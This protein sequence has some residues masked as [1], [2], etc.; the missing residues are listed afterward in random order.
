MNYLILGNGFDLAH[1]YKTRYQDFL[2]WVKQEV[3]LYNSLDTAARMGIKLLF[4]ADSDL[5][6]TNDS[7][8]KT[9]PN[10]QQEIWECINCNFWLEYFIY[11]LD[12][13]KD[14]WTGFEN[15]ISL[16][17]QRFD[18]VMRQNMGQRY[19]N[20]ISSTAL[21]CMS[22]FLRANSTH[23]RNSVDPTKYI[24]AEVTTYKDMIDRFSKDLSS[25]I[26]L[27]EIYLLYFSKRNATKTPFPGLFNIAIDRVVSFNYTDTYSKLYN[28]K[29]EVNYIHG[30]ADRKHP[31]K[32]DN[33]VLGID[34]YLNDDRASSELEFIAFKKYYQRIRKMADPQY[35]G[36]IDEI[37]SDVENLHHSL[38]ADVLERVHKDEC[39]NDR[40]R[41][42]ITMNR[43]FIIGHS[44]DKT[45][46]DVLKG[47]IKKDNVRTTIYYYNDEDYAQK[48]ANLIQVLGKDDLIKR[49]AGKYQTIYFVKQSE[50]E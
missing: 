21:N 1:G 42:L 47:F 3:N 10:I 39:D 18:S 8:G 19:I 9:Y 20:P 28:D 4:N 17:I 12:K 7:V 25:L 23:I 5:L 26:R 29:C 27:F 46:A 35:L 30:V 22:E 40:Y 11:S 32:S 34:E 50:L 14:G 36:W 31:P 48:V 15:E 6:F 49:T 2:Y 33:M 43:V 24:I 37:S 38:H 44:L 45:D 13:M 16:V 41:E